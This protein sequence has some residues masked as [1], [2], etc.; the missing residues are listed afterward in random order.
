[1]RQAE[2][3]HPQD[4]VHVGLEH[5]LLV[6]LGTG[7]EGLAAEAEAGVVDEDV[8]PAQRRHRAGHEALAAGGVGHVELEPD[9]GLELVHAPS[10]A[11]DLCAC[12][13]QRARRRGPDP[14]RG[15]GDDRGPALEPTHGVGL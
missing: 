10:A 7:V 2:A 8:E 3:R 14:A 9:L 1:V 12:L 6:L 13:R 11:G 5:G 4:T 15:A